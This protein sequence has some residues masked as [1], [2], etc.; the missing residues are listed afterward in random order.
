M[1]NKWSLRQ[2]DVKNAFL[3]GHLTEH[4]YM[5]NLL[6]ILTPASLIISVS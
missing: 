1:T 3:N 4:F 6:G 5:D 2:L